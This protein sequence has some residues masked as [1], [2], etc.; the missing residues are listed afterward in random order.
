MPIIQP[1]QP[2][3]FVTAAEL[4]DK[5]VKEQTKLRGHLS[6]PGYLLLSFLC[7]PTGPERLK[8]PLPVNHSR[9][10]PAE[11]SYTFK[12]TLEHVTYI[13]E[14]LNFLPLSRIFVI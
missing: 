10:G 9:N 1:T 14:I 13:P 12:H 7:L 2:V 6:S 8:L 11:P 3:V 4:T 5:T